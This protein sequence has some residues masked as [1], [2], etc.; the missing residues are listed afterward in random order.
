MSNCADLQ[1]QYNTLVSQQEL[2][3]RQFN[4]Q[5]QIS[6]LL[7]KSAEALVCGPACQKAKVSE[8]LKQKW[9]DAQTNLQTAPINLETSRKNFYVYT[10]G[11]PFYDNLLE[12][13]LKQKAEHIAGLIAES[14][15]DEL[16]SALTMN[17]YYKTDVLN[18]R[19]TE[20]LLDKI[21][22]ENGALER[23][24]KNS[25]TDILT[26][27]RKTYYEQS[28]YEQLQLWYRFWWYIY[29]IVTLMFVIAVF[30][31]PSQ[32]SIAV[33]IGLILLLVFYPYYISYIVDWTHDFGMG[34]YNS[35]PKT[36][37]NN[38]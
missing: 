10:E 12:Q 15:N 2:L 7:E 24:L 5:N 18:S 19:N 23:K 38:L 4:A 28:A 26:N 20:E 25:H 31:S 8:Q 35:F 36:V 17:Q 32:L 29:Y 3:Q 16:T 13:E 27:D 6:S 11:Q 14:F 33:K 34:I 37:Y 1:N 9:L 21:I 22:A 30:A